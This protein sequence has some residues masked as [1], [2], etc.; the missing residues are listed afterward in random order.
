[1]LYLLLLLT[2]RHT[3]NNINNDNNDNH[4]DHDNHDNHDLDLYASN[5]HHPSLTSKRQ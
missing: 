3:H 4:H 5:D 1:M 2:H